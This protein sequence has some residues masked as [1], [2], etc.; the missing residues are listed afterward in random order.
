MRLPIL[1]LVLSPLVFGCGDDVSPPP[2]SLDGS[3]DSNDADV[4][5]ADAGGSDAATDAPSADD[6]GV[7]S[8]LLGCTF[9]EAGELSSSGA[10]RS[11]GAQLAAT[12]NGFGVVYSASPEGPENIYY[13]FVQPTGPASEAVLIT[14]DNNISR[15]PAITSFGSGFLVGWYDNESGGFEIRSRVIEG[16]GTP[17]SEPTMLSDNLLR[18]DAPALAALPS[19]AL[20]VWVEDDDRAL[21]RVLRGALLDDGGAPV[22]PVLELTDE[23]NAVDRPVIRPLG[24]GA[25]VAWAEGNGT[26]RNARGLFVN[27]DGSI[28]APVALSETG[29]VGSLAFA[30]NETGALAYNV[31]GGSAAEVWVLPVGADGAPSGEAQQVNVTGDEGGAPA[32]TPFEDGYVAIFP[33][34]NEDGEAVVRLSAVDAAGRPL[35]FLD[36][37][38]LTGDVG[39]LSA[40]TVGDTLMLAWGITELRW[41]RISCP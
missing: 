16:N 26:M 37:P 23:A 18:D 39:I 5:R 19:G 25:F 17:S 15:S 12:P 31:G 1:A 9:G 33:A 24:N 4:T 8:P 35:G 34:R 38:P 27:A 13:R 20:A 32:I 2:G 3:T 29:G 30:G 11:N 36:G 28:E 10:Q 22:G 14:N 40:A 41:V 7:P 6:A 21:T